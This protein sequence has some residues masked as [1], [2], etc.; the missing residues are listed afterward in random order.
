VSDSSS[1]GP[2]PPLP[3]PAPAP[4]QGAELLQAIQGWIVGLT[5]MS[6]DLVRPR[7]QAEPPTIPAADTAWAAVGIVRRISEAFPNVAHAAAGFDQVNRNET[8]E[9]VASFYDLGYS[10]QADDLASLFRDGAAIAQNR[11]ALSDIGIF[12]ADLGE[13][14]AVPVLTNE[15]WLYRVDVPFSLRRTVSR[16]YAIDNVEEA[17][18]TI[19]AEPSSGT[20]QTIPLTIVSP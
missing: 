3:P 17:A 12:L 16:Q 14:L 8:L 2:L 19:E 6:G 10:G 18:V 13:S 1:G 4:L 20:A 7:W 11:E 15:R 9:C 5:G